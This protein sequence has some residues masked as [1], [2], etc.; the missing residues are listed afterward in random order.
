MLDPQAIHG[1][2]NQGKTM[3]R[4]SSFQADSKVIANRITG[5][6]RGEAN[7]SIILACGLA[8]EKVCI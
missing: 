3:G 6:I 4:R 5:A 7:C 1:L 8:I 2:C